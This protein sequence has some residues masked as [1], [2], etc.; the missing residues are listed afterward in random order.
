MGQTNYMVSSWY[1]T[2]AEILLPVHSSPQSILSQYVTEIDAV[3]LY[4]IV[5]FGSVLFGT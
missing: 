4:P 2:R 1:L 3:L 5:A